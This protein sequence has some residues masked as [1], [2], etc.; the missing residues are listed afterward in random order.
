MKY[1][2]HVGQLIYPRLEKKVS[3]FENQNFSY[4]ELL[5]TSICKL[6]EEEKSPWSATI[7]KSVCP[8]S[9]LE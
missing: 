1:F 2:L 8:D 9:F 4:R 5:L 7:A 6:I 3:T